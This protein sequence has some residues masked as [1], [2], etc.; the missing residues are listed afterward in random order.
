MAVHERLPRGS[1]KTPKPIKTRCP[2]SFIHQKTITLLL[3]EHTKTY[4]TVEDPQNRLY[5]DA[6]QEA[7][8]TAKTQAK[9]GASSA[10]PA[11][12][13]ARPADMPHRAL[14]TSICWFRTDLRIHDNPSLVA[15]LL[16]Q[17]STHLLPLYIL[18]P[19][20]I[21]L[22]RL[23]H[24]PFTAARTRHYRFPRCGIHRSRFLCQA[25]DD[26]RARLQRHGSTLLVRYGKPE[27]VLPGIVNALLSNGTAVSN[28]HCA[29]DVAAEEITIEQSVA[30]RLAALGVPL[31]MHDCGTMVALA[32][33]PFPL[34]NLPDVYTAFR[35][36][37]EALPN[38]VRPCV[39]VP[40]RF[41]LLPDVPPPPP[42]SAYPTTDLADTLLPL[43]SPLPIP[44][45]DARS[46]HPF[47]GG[48][49]AALARL[50][51]YLTTHAVATYKHTRN[52]LVGDTYSTKFSAFLSHGC[53]SPR[54]IYHALKKYEQQHAHTTDTYWV[55]F[56]LLWR[57]YFR[58]V[59]LKHGSKLFHPYSLRGCAKH[60]WSTD[61]ESST[62]LALCGGVTG[63]PFI[64]ASMRE[65]VATGY[66]SNRSRQNVASFV[67]KDLCLDW[68]IGAELYES[69]LV[70]HDPSSNYGNWAYA[71]GIGNDPREDRKFNVIKQAFDYDPQGEYV[72]LWI[73]EL[74]DLST[75]VVH[76]PW[77]TPLPKEVYPHPIV[78]A[79]EWKRH[80]DR[81][82]HEND[83]QVVG[84]RRGM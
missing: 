75:A 53:L 83:R 78:I 14:V 31:I 46:A 80:A 19:R 20:Y 63:V 37:V 21:D 60:A 77:K 73:P 2:P 5:K 32:D 18:D 71:A 56:E 38:M 65:L 57:D 81:G 27:D 26:L 39:A 1:N 52:G 4:M 30:K 40:P 61:V 84:K 35:T 55:I 41:K 23:P 47:R 13:R 45:M 9:G 64:D 51:A 44:D 7:K 34:R 49:T 72:R 54:T 3:P 33:L 48:E 42:A 74:C 36:R 15:S 17:A 79:P 70:D 62:A 76:V 11:S 10:L 8:V 69:H 29:M 16:D 50:N 59:A 58:F 24:S 25:L 82:N 6:Q 22:S 12:T 66:T 68:R 43:V 28:V 67:T